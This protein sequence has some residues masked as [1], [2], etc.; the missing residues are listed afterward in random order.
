MQTQRSFLNATSSWDRAHDPV[1]FSLQD[2]DLSYPLASKSRQSKP[3][4]RKQLTGICSRPQTSA[5][6]YP[7]QPQPAKK[8]LAQSGKTL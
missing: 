5:R 1:S 6:M 7:P 3:N 2:L 8:S 4:R